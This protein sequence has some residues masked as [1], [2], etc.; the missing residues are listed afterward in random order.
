MK[1]LKK[2]KSVYYKLLLSYATLLIVTTVAVG[3]T[4]YLFFTTSLNEEVEKVHARMLVHTSEQ[5]QGNLLEKTE[6]IY[7]DLATNTD[8]LYFFDNPLQ[9]NYA[10][11]ND[12]LQ[13]L[14]ITNSLHQNLVDSISVYYRNSNAILS[15]KQGISL[16]DSLPD[17]VTVSTD[18]ITRMNQSDAR[19]QWLETRKV[20]ISLNSNAFAEDITSLVGVY[21][22]HSTGMKAQG[23]IAINLKAE[24]I[25]QMIRSTDQ[26]DQSQ[27]WITDNA[28][29]VIASEKLES[30]IGAQ[31]NRRL[32][33][34]IQTLGTDKGSFSESVGGVASLVSYTTIPSSGWMVVQSTPIDEYNQKA[35]AIQRTLIIICL[36][37]IVVGLIVSNVLTSNMYSPLKTLLQTVGNLFGSSFP[38]AVKHENEYKQID[39]FVANLSIKMSGLEA[40]VS[41][42][43]PVIR[44]NLVFGLLNRTVVH[45][46][47]LSER[48]KFLQLDWSFPHYNVLIIRLDEREMNELQ[49]KNRQIVVYTLIR[50]LEQLDIEGASCTAISISASD[51]AAIVHS[52]VQDEHHIHRIMTLLFQYAEEQF[53]LHPIAA[54]G[55]WV[56]DPLQLHQAYREAQ[57]YLNYRFFTPSIR[58]YMDSE[59]RD[60]GRSRIEIPE[61]LAE[62]FTDA[63]KS[64][65][66]SMLK[67]VLSEFVHMLETGRYS[68]EDGHEKWRQWI[69]LYHQYIKEMHLK[70]SEVMTGEVLDYFQRIANIH[71]FQEWLLLAT[72]QTFRFVEERTYNKSGET[73]EKVKLYVEGNLGND[74]SLQV[75][76]ESV[77]LHPRYLSQLFK[78]ET[79][80]NFVD[81]V[82]KRRI[83]TAANLIKSTDLNVEKIAYKVGFNTPAYFIKKF[84][85]MYGVT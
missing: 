54:S 13:S 12:I 51:I 24:A 65:D 21:P 71:E 45:A 61:L 74:L 66:R 10:R 62:R 5:L 18:W 15:S 53:L 76:A 9:G 17:K 57:D 55:G 77:N 81:Y 48:L 20:P 43:M 41:E 67:T 4:S 56:D 1:L 26:S 80:I 49:E 50:E 33:T 82:N 36:A 70:S 2:F 84:K 30:P 75:V 6:R 46:S 72:D 3:T 23:F 64:R 31:E 11:V 42:N 34:Q 39:G 69:R 60:R 47:E 40:A 38:T 19:I 68:A 63:L 32:L 28:G 44:H 79:G 37:S 35:A 7:A 52:S 16:L 29:H 83:E 14:R 25:H 78:E 8:V 85:E 59:Y 58:M 27:L 22:Y 73:I